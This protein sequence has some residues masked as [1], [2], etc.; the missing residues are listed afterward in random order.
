[1]PEFLI[2]WIV[3]AVSLII[4]AN[5]IPGIVIASWTTAAI[6]AIVLG[7]VNAIVKP[8]LILLTLPL[9]ILTLGLFLLIVN[10]ISLSLVAYFTPGF[11][12]SSFWD[13]LIGSIV[14]SFVTWIINLLLG[15]RE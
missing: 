13:A 5:L 1:M 15:N 4:T 11:D 12:I 10:A 7:L 8:I 3:T 9:T 2:T 14:L 6:A